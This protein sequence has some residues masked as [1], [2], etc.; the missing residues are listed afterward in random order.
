M[1]KKKPKKKLEH[2]LRQIKVKAKCTKA[3]DTTKAVDVRERKFIAGMS[4][5]KEDE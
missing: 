3:R 4:Y 1:S 5:I 2:S